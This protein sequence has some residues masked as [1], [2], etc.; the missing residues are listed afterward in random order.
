MKITKKQTK[1]KSKFGIKLRVYKTK[2]RQAEFAYVEVKKGHL[3]EFYNKVSTFF[4]YI[5]EGKGKFFLNG[6]ATPVKATDLLVI[7]PKT[8]IYYLGKMKLILVT[9]PAWSAKDEVY[10]R[11]IELKKL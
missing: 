8:K 9:A 6:V 10:V 5:L 2:Y 7:P 1:I 11:N 4:Y 3:E